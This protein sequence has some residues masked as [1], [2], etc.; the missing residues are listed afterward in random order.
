MPNQ[1]FLKHQNQI[2]LSSR[3]SFPT[4]FHNLHAFT[5]FHW[6]CREKCCK[7]T[8][9]IIDTDTMIMINKSLEVAQQVPW[10]PSQPQGEIWRAGFILGKKNTAPVGQ[11]LEMQLHPLSTL[12]G[13][14][15]CFSLQIVSLAAAIQIWTVKHM[16]W[17]N[18]VQSSMDSES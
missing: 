8:E 13:C 7:N 11:V 17:S 12:G 14:R 3:S 10:N 15:R 1:E 18:I 9:K 16:I 6:F 5:M 2:S 4:F